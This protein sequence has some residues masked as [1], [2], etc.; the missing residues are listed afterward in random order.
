MAWD[1]GRCRERGGGGD[2][3]RCGSGS[4]FGQ[5]QG[6]RPEQGGFQGGRADGAQATEGVRIPQVGLAGEELGDDVKEKLGTSCVPRQKA[7]KTF[8]L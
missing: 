7:V 8:A 4:G 1:G 3:G 6:P 2:E 5:P